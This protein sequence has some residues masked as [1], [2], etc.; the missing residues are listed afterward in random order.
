MM[1]SLYSGVAGLKTHQTKMDVIGNNIANVNTTSFK[2]QSITFSDLMYQTTQTAS[3]AT[4]TKGG[5]N[6][7][8]IGL[9][10]KSGAINT[11]ITSQGATQTTNNPF[12]IMI[13][14][15]AFFVVNNGNENLYTRDGSFYVDGAGNLAMQSNGYFVQ[16]WVAQEDKETGEIT[17]NKNG[18]LSSLQIM[19]AANSTY[20]PAS[21]TAAL[22][23]GNIDDHDKN[24]ISDDGKTVTLEFYDNKGYLYTGKFTLKDTGYDHQ[25]ALTLTDIIDSDG[26]SIGP[27]LLKEITFGNV[28]SPTRSQSFEKGTKYSIVLDASGENIAINAEGGDVKYKQVPLTGYLSDL[29]STSS[30]SYSGIL[31]TVYNVTDTDEKNYPADATYKIDDQT[32]ELTIK[33]NKVDLAAADGWYATAKYTYKTNSSEKYFVDP[34]TL[35]AYHIPDSTANSSASAFADTDFLSKVFGIADTYGSADYDYTYYNATTPPKMEIKRHVSVPQATTTNPGAY[36]KIASVGQYFTLDGTTTGKTV[37]QAA[38]DWVDAAPAGET[39]S[40]DQVFYAYNSADDTISLYVKNYEDVTKTE[41]TGGSAVQ[42]DVD[43]LTATF[44]EGTIDVSTGIETQDITDVLAY[45]DNQIAAL[46][47]D[48]QTQEQNKTTEQGNIDTQQGIID[49]QNQIISDAEAIINDPTADPT[50][51]AQAEADR[52][53]AVAARDQAVLDKAAAQTAYDDAVAA[54]TNNDAKIANYNSAKKAAEEIQSAM[55]AKSLSVVTDVKGTTITG[56]TGLMYSYETQELGGAQVLRDGTG[57]IIYYSHQIEAQGDLNTTKFTDEQPVQPKGVYVGAS[58]FAKAYGLTSLTATITSTNNPYETLL[59]DAFGTNTNIPSLAS[60]QEYTITFSNNTDTLGY[61]SIAHSVTETAKGMSTGYSVSDNGDG[62][63]NYTSETAYESVPVKGNIADLLT[64][65][66]GDNKGLLNKVYGITDEQADAY[67]IDGTYE[68]NTSTG[69]INLTVGKHSVQLKFDAANGSLVSAD[70]SDA[71]LVTMNFNQ[72]IPGLEAFGYQQTA[73]DTTHNPGDVQFDFSTVTNYNTN[74]SST[75]K[76]V[77]G[78]KKS[79]NTGRAVGEMNG[80]S[81]STDGQIYATYSNGQTKLLGQIASA[82]FANASGLSKEGDNLYAS[83]LNSGEATIQDITTDGGY[84]NTGVLEM[85]NVDLSSQFTEMITTQRGFQ[86]N[87][88]IITVSDTL[89]EELTNLKR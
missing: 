34:T 13:T 6:A 46:N 29:M 1:R 81:I 59:G 25:F 77:K 72:S 28:E 54:I 55:T 27:D 43:N 68:I 63:L 65:A 45:I 17:I 61:V 79:L 60:G 20:S 21:T 7:R 38:Q 31:N 75:I 62:T 74:G 39:R 53:A 3:G 52:N 12:D 36:S 58:T 69:A 78:D 87:S 30:K 11:A 89:L 50:D 26:K 88:R 42:A 8:Q 18:G 84:M 22:Y 85:S 71:G 67:G 44:T 48:N 66:E 80:V 15:E 64:T 40:L 57:A 5:V 16:G 23:S 2:S 73:G 41:A 9:G 70:T 82:E 56:T 76:A 32:G 86:A 51:V 49:A 35:E 24:L 37:L 47:A 19:S 10:A 33:Y 14:G 4:E 83:T